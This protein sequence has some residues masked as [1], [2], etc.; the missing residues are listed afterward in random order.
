M[1]MASV[2]NSPIIHV[3]TVQSLG[4]IKY[5]YDDNYDAVVMMLSV[6]NDMD[7]P[8]YDARCLFVHT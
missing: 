2:R 8:Y 7:D 4:S 1:E 5:D 3:C 6:Y